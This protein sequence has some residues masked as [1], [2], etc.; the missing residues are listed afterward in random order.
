MTVATIRELVKQASVIPPPIEA[1]PLPASCRYE[2]LSGH[3]LAKRDPLKWVCKG[4]LPAEGVAAFYGAP[5][6]AKTFLVLDLLAA[7]GEA[8]EWFGYRTTSAPVVY[9]GLEGEAG[10]SQRLRA[11]LSRW[12]LPDRM[13]FVVNPW[14][15][16]EAT[17]RLQLIRS[18]L[19]AGMAGGVLAIDTLNRSAPGSDENSSQDMGNVIAGLREVQAALGGLVLAVHHSGKDSS[20][21]LRGHSSLLGTLDAAI[22]VKRDGEKRSWL[23]AKSKDGTDGIEH[24]FAL[25]IVDLG[26]DEDGDQITSCIVMPREIQVS[27]KP[28]RAPAPRGTHQKLALPPILA[29]INFEGVAKPF[30]PAGAPVKAIPLESAVDAGAT[31]LVVDSKHRRTR[32]REAIGG[33]VSSGFLAFGE[34]FVWKS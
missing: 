14:D 7:I 13:R 19:D 10:L 12:P 22:E 3:D 25:S 31:A 11:Y 17:D 21:G 29:C 26:R 16:R 34:D 2:L 30:G 15:V 8:R 18:I 4:V 6:S 23:L 27:T 1:A 9:L 32:A 5:G 28:E 20:R 24:G 33:L